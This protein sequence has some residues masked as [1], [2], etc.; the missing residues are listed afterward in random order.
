MVDPEKT[1]PGIIYCQY[2]PNSLVKKP[3]E[4]AFKPGSTSVSASS[5][6][7]IKDPEEAGSRGQDQMKEKM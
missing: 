3:E 2:H 1:L 7:R 4:L 5:L 6:W